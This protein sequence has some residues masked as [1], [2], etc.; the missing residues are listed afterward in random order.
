MNQI[1]RH[2]PGLL[3]CSAL[4]RLVELRTLGGDDGVARLLGRGL[5]LAVVWSLLEIVVG[6]ID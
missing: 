3:R 5:L 6:V 2:S 4:V 1:D